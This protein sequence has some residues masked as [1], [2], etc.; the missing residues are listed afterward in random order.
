MRVVIVMLLASC[1][2]AAVAEPA[3]K[4]R[5]CYPTTGKLSELQNGILTMER[6]DPFYSAGK[7]R[8][9]Q[10]VAVTVIKNVDIEQGKCVITDVRP[11]N[12]LDAREDSFAA[13]GRTLVN[14][15]SGASATIIEDVK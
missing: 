6:G 12:Y 14:S 2:A 10:P 13:H 1:G 4:A 15:S 7:K 3:G 5:I 11:M 8:A 9:N